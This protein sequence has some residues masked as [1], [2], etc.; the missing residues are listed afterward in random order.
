M[1]RT[2]SVANL[3]R[4]EG[5]GAL[6]LTI[7]D[8]RVTGANF[9]IFESPRFFEAFLRGRRGAEAP[10]LTAR[11]C[12][13]CPVAYQMSAVHAAGGRSGPQRHRPLT[14]PAPSAL[15]R[16][17]DRK[18][19]PARLFS[20]CPRL[21]GLRRRHCHGQG[22]S[23]N[24]QGSSGAEKSRQRDRGLAGRPGGSSHQRPGGRLLSGAPGFQSCRLSPAPWRGPWIWPSKPCAGSRASTSRT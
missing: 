14:G 21:P 22:L 17:M 3:A 19:R 7:K 8:G 6:E 15:L 10:D 13:I 5:E 1:H 11:I 4:V 2:I 18:P 24:R 12:G 20:A 9:S 23:R 16:G